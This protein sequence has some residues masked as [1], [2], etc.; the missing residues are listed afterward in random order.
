MSNG[1]SE[2]DEK[3]CT[4]EHSVGEPEGLE[5]DAEN[6]DRAADNYGRASTEEI[7]GV[8]D[9]WQRSEGTDGHDTV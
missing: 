1:Y 7:G 6:H 5:D 4:D 8:G 3:T 9:D 2:A